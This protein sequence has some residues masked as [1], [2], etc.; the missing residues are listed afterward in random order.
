MKTRSE[1]TMAFAVASSNNISLTLWACSNFLLHMKTRL[2]FKNTYIKMRFIFLTTF[3]TFVVSTSALQQTFPRTTILVF[4]TLIFF[5]D[6]KN[7][8]KY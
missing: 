1:V 3:G 4:E 8:T 6:D 2:R 5:V 7:F